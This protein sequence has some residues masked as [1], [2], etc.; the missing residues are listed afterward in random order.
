MSPGPIL[1]CVNIRCNLIGLSGSSSVQ[2][3]VNSR[4]DE[5]IFSVRQYLFH[6]L[7]PDR[8]E[9]DSEVLSLFFCATTYI[10]LRQFCFQTNNDR[11]TFIPTALIS[12]VDGDFIESNPGSNQRNANVTSDYYHCVIIT[13]IKIIY[14]L[15]KFVQAQI[16]VIPAAR[17]ITVEEAEPVAWWVIFLPILAA[18][19]VISVV[20]ILLWVVSMHTN[21]IGS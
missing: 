6:A 19:I 21:A 9:S 7:I 13:T 4:L 1:N 10:I 3:D 16:P 2:V 15:M 5:R 11:Y 12:I 14:N 8:I 17:V 18:V 20:T